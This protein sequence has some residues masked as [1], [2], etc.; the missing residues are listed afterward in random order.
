M[1]AAPPATAPRS[2]I[3]R[4]VVLLGAAVVVAAAAWSGFW[5]WLAGQ[6]EAGTATAIAAAARDGTTIVCAPRS[7]GGYPFRIEVRCGD[8]SVAAPAEGILSGRGLTAVA[9]AYDPRRLILELAG[10]VRLT[11]ADGPGLDAAWERARASVRLAADGLEAAA[12]SVEAARLSIAGRPVA[13]VGLIELHA[14]RDP[15]EASG[16]DLAVTV[17]KASTPG[18]AGAALDASLVA[19]LGDGGASLAGRGPLVEGVPPEGIPVRL[20]RAAVADGATA[21]DAAGTVTL[22]PDGRLDGT[23]ELTLQDPAAFGA[24]MAKLVP[25]GDP[26]PQAIAGAAS[27]FGRPAPDGRGRVLPLKLAAGKVAVGLIPLGTIPPLPVRPAAG[28]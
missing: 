23:I 20:V 8:I 28:S 24:L 11:P 21:A 13:S 15:G 22:R 12:V 2:S 14:R 27:A 10:P 5:W 25:P 4:R 18:A 1:T 17:G 3:R 16:T 26:L 9:L 7:V 6:V 19:V